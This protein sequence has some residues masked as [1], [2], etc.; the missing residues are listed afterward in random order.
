MDKN[1]LHVLLLLLVDHV[2]F[3]NRKLDNKWSNNKSG[4]ASLNNKTT[5]Q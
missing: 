5:P 3:P 4:I 2:T 1:L